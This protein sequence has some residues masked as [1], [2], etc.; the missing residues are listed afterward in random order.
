MDP[1]QESCYVFLISG[2]S[3]LPTGHWSDTL[4]LDPGWKSMLLRLCTL[5]TSPSACRCLD[6]A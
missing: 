4:V 6:P 5:P 3:L 1:A 2:C